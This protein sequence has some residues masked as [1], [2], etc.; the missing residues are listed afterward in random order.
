MRNLILFFLLIICIAACNNKQDPVILPIGKMKVV[1]WQLIRADEYYTRKSFS[2][3]TFK[4][5][6]MNVKYYQ[7]IFD[8]NKVDRAD[9]YKTIN[10]Y[11]SH[12]VLFKEVLDSVSELSKREKKPINPA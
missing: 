5:N 10:Y 4:K 2:D 3:S 6:K 8:L 7:Q 12:P 11:Y 1:M 9:F